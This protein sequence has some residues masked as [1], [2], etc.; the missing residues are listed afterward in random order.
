MSLELGWNLKSWAVEITS[1]ET[2]NGEESSAPL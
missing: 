2:V 1:G